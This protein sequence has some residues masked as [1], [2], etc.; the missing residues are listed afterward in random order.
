M[1]KQ[2]IITW[3]FQ[4]LLLIF[5][6]AVFWCNFVFNILKRSMKHMQTSLFG[7]PNKSEKQSAIIWYSSNTFCSNFCFDDSQL[8]I[9]FY[10]FKH[11]KSTIHILL[12]NT[13]WICKEIARGSSL[14][15][16]LDDKRGWSQKNSRPENRNGR[17]S[18][19]EKGWNHKTSMP[20][21][22]KRF[23]SIGPRTLCHH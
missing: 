4:Y 21:I 15:K 20:Q 17:A 13:A 5:S 19:W 18:W 9:I 16:S 2:S 12:K 1:W 14:S 8:Q 6:F 11:I 3:Y 23:W 22:E 10:I 7:F